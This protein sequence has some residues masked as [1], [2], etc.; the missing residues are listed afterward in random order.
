MEPELI[1]QVGA[2]AGVIGVALA[3]FFLLARTIVKKDIFPKLNRTQA[4][5]TLRYVLFL[6][7]LLTLFGMIAWLVGYALRPPSQSSSIYSRT[8]SPSKRT[9]GTSN[10]ATSRLHFLRSREGYLCYKLFQ[11][12]VLAHGDRRV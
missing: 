7:F 9:F 4:F 5:R 1:R 6:S 3:L 11:S 8:P 2:V 10:R 12:S